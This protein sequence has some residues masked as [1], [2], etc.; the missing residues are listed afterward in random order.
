MKSNFS[1][2]HILECA[3]VL[4]L[5]AF[6]HSSCGYRIVGSEFLTFQSVTIASVK[7]QTYEPQLEERLHIALS[8]EFIRQG[9]EVKV[10]GGDVDLE[11]TVTLFQLGAV[12][13]VDEVIK[14]QEI[15]MEVDIQ[16]DDKGKVAMFKSMRSPIKITFQS[17]GSVN[18]AAARKDIATEKA[19]S[20]IAKEIVGQLIVRY[21]K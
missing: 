19:C 10:K 13:A 21:A 15:I 5:T 9:I 20:E 11:S 12:G 2:R 14:E 4:L 17:T 8:R 3:L 1:N 16:V 6:F 18:E 7:N